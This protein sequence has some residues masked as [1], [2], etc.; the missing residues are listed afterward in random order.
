MCLSG[1]AKESVKPV[2]CHCPPYPKAGPAVADEL[3]KIDP[4]II[5]ATIE[6]IQ[7][8]DRMADQIEVQ[9]GPI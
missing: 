7:R 5:P 4:A 8:L 9:N 3:E 1:C 6:W 2:L